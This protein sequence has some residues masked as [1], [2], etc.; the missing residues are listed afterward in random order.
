MVSERYVQ[1]ILVQSSETPRA[2]AIWDDTRLSASAIRG[3]TSR[4]K[5][6]VIHARLAR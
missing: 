4:A 6:Q 3:E 1:R 5:E 2:V